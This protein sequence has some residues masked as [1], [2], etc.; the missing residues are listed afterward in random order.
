MYNWK[1][2]KLNGVEITRLTL[3]GNLVWEKKSDNINGYYALVANKSAIKDVEISA[4]KEL[5]ASG[6]PIVPET[7]GILTVL[8]NAVSNPTYE[9]NDPTFGW[10]DP[11]SLRE[12]SATTGMDKEINGITYKLWYS[13]VPTISKS[14]EFKINY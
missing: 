14:I 7:D 12:G 5:P 2:C 10:G 6:I 9:I 11:T 13:T 1:S 3:N 4:F 8:V